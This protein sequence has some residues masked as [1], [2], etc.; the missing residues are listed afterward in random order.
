MASTLALQ[1]QGKLPLDRQQANDRLK[2]QL[3]LELQLYGAFAGFEPNGFDDQDAAFSG[4]SA[5]GSD[6]K[7]RFMPYFY[8][9]KDQI[10]TD[11]LLSIKK[12]TRTNSAIPPTTTT[13]ARNGK[14]AFASSISSRW[15]STVNR[16]W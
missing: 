3:A 8:R 7:G 10:G 12:L 1:Q 16:C 2:A 13:P 15:T 5:L 14:V 11:L 9:N 6:D 4:Q